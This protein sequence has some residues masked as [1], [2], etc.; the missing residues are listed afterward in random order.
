MPQLQSIVLKDGAATPVNHTFT[1]LDIQQGVG[2]VVESAGVPI[3]NSKFTV[4]L[5]KTPNGRYRATL[6]L[7]VPVVVN[8]T[9]NGVTKP[10]VA[11]TA[12]ANVTFT[13]EDSS[14]TQ[15]RKDIMAMISDALVTGTPKALVYDTV[16]GLQAVY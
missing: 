8:E 5:S 2:A 7:S 11:R 4:G 14:S 6:N 15:E 1:P 3:G 10:T 13:F 16:V 12:Y 9:V